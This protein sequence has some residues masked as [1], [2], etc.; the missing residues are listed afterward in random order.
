MAPLEGLRVVEAALGISA[1]GAGPAVSLPGTLLRDLGA[2]VTRVRP[3]R[4]STLDAGVEFD[5]V[6]DRGKEIVEVGDDPGRAA[7]A[8][9]A[10]ARD[11]DVLVVAG[12]E[13]AVERR[14]LRYQDLA[15]ESPRLVVTRVRPSHNALGPVPDLE[16]LVHARAG[17]LTQIRGHRPGPVFGDLTVASAGAGL[18]ATAGTLARLYERE[19]TGLGGWV[20]TSLYD[21]LQALLPMIIGRVEHHSPSTTLLWKEQGPAEALSYR[22][23]DGEYVQLWFGAKGAYEAFLDHVGDPPSEKGYNADLMSGA[24]VERGERWAAMF[25]TRD[26][27]RWVEDLS[28]KNFRC[29]P[30]WRPGEA[31]RDPHVREIGLSADH[32]DPDRG[33]I[34]ALGPVVRV[35]RT[36]DGAPRGGGAPTAGDAAGPLA[37][38]RVLDLSAYLAGPIAPLVLAG[39]GADVVKVEPPG[40]DAHRGMEPMFAAGQRGKRALALDL[41]SPGAPAVLERLFRWSDV[42]HHNSRVGAAERLGYDEET[43]R[44]ANPDAVYSFASGFGERGPRALLPANDQLMQALAGVEAA[45][46][47]DGRP[48][49]YLVWG[50]V[51]VTGGWLAACGILAGLYARRRRGGGQSVAGSLLGAALT[52]KSGAFRTADGVVG[53]PVLDAEQ[54]GYGAAYRLYQGGDGAW[55]ALAVPD[56]RAWNCLREVTGLDGL[57]ATPPPLRTGPS[58]PQ[59]EE[60]LLE[61]AFRTRDAA[62]WTAALRAAGV[63]VEPVPD[64]DRT[65]FAAGFVDDPVNRRLGRV[66]GYRWGA[67]GRVDQPALPPRV[68]PGPETPAPAGIPGLGEHTDEV[69]RELGLDAAGAGTTGARR[70]QDE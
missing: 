41:K 40:G 50:A 12:A 42:V 55:F 66:V 8:V 61:D 45:Q 23:A 24:M 13:D 16:L 68:G 10:L 25:A 56:E 59:P 14:G 65:E 30:V 9:A 36:R 5:R 6:W 22:C 58:G 46:G 60:T 18:S 67:R 21:G 3:A 27:D 37:G 28:G 17:L 29:E 53:G 54:T 38:V 44:A 2:E 49:T 48:P 69:L 62:A 1:V 32:H 70:R 11:A 34:T 47:G 35:T 20:E 26:R 43:V 52:L 63:P 7:G 4:R 33:A 51:D 64:A 31:L 19:S 15:R 39:L 57:P